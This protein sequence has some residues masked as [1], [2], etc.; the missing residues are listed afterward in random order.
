MQLFHSIQHV[1]K[2]D[3]KATYISTQL[4]LSC[5]VSVFLKWRAVA[6]LVPESSALLWRWCKDLEGQE[7]LNLL[8]LCC[9]ICKCWLM[10]R[11]MAQWQVG[12]SVSWHV[13]ASYYWCCGCSFP[14]PSPPTWL[15]ASPISFP[16]LFTSQ[17]EQTSVA[18][19]YVS[20]QLAPV[21]LAHLWPQLWWMPQ[22]SPMNPLNQDPPVVQS[23]RVEHGQNLSYTQP[24]G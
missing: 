19:T 9:C 8:Q 12:G 3:L 11:C 20:A 15:R 13:T 23:D 16:F 21:F 6:R 22:G 2:K 14:I 10:D 5:I 1:V 4:N 17:A 24:T 18:A 7:T